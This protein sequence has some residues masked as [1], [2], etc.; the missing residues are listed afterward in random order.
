MGDIKKANGVSSN[1][2]N[3]YTSMDSVAA[4]WLHKSGITGSGHWNFGSERRRDEVQIFGE[5]GNIKCSVFG[6]APIC[7]EENSE[8]KKLS[9]ENP[10]SIQIYHVQNMKDDLSGVANHP[11]TGKSAAHTSWVLDQILKKN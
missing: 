4:S 2:Q 3:L 9:I 10:K 6:D 7:I 5:K 11:S 8:S 1:Q